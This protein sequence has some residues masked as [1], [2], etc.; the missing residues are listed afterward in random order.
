MAVLA[1]RFLD[2]DRL[3]VEEQQEGLRHNPPLT[4]IDGA[5]TQAKWYLRLKR[6]YRRALEQGETF[7]NPLRAATVEWLC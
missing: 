6:D 2:Q 3:V 1:G 7:Q 5:D 4:L